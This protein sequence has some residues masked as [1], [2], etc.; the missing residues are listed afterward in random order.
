M[1]MK[2]ADETGRKMEGD[3]VRQI[4]V[5]DRRARAESER[6]V[7]LWQAGS[8]GQIPWDHIDRYRL[9]MTCC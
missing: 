6:G 7:V 5:A 1:K 8:A 9:A 4:S 3:V 2:R